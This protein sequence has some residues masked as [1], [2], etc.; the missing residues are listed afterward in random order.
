MLSCV[1]S[2]EPFWGTGTRPTSEA[3]TYVPVYAT[4]QDYL[5]IQKVAAKAIE[6]PSK[7]FTYN[8]YLIVNI[9]NEGFHVID[10]SNPKLP[11][12]LFFVEVPG[13]NDVAVKDGVIYAD[14]YSDIVAFTVEANGDLQILERLENMIQH[15]SVPPFTNVYF[16]CP[17]PSKGIVVDWIPGN[18]DNPKCYR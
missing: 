3:L 17:D 12:N 14:N 18:V 7:I 15:N 11:K 10:N 13:N 16:E 2:D 8:N 5:N 1:E 4:N 9:K 6:N